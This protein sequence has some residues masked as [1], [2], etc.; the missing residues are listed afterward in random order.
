[1]FNSQDN[2]E[3]A[4]EESSKKAKFFFS[5][6]VQ[7]W[8]A[9]FYI[10]VDNNIGLDLGKKVTVYFVFLI[11]YLYNVIMFVVFINQFYF[12]FSEGLIELLESRHGQ[13]SVYI[14]CMKSGEVVSEV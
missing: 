1:M 10:K 5:T 9:E 7:N 8:D 14:G 4:D 2:H 12:P 13:D 11:I 3:E 6:A